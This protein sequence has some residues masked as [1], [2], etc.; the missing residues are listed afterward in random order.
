MTRARSIANIGAAVESSL[1]FRNR[2]INGDMRIDQRNAGA[3]I[4]PLDAQYSVDRWGC[5]RS[6]ASKYV[7]QQNAGGVTPPVGFTNYLGATSA[8][9]YSSASS[10]YFGIAQA[11]EG[12]NTADLMFG[13]ANARTVT[14]SFWVRSSLTGTFGGA[15]RNSAQN[16]NFCFSYTVSAANTWEFKTVTVAG[17][18]TGTWLTNN[19]TGIS[20]WFDLGS[21]STLTG[22]AGSWGAANVV[23]PSGSVSLVGTSGATFYVTGVQF[24]A[25][26][27][28]SPFERRNY[29]LELMMCQRYFSAFTNRWFTGYAADTSLQING[30]PLPV[31]MRAGPTVVLSGSDTNSNVHS[32]ITNDVTSSN[33]NFA[34]TTVG[35]GWFRIRI[36]SA[37][38]SAEL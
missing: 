6:Q 33:L 2:I 31:T 7:V 17:D 14:M 27:V 16:R 30:S 18:T 13:T 26:S 9:A 12:L 24:E 38:F 29:G 10:D 20:V 22:A 28:A 23:R 34:V 8:S 32:L 21:G 1:G 4:T 37:T 11:I 3:S 15:L 36:L 25:G 5:Y 19:G 35:A